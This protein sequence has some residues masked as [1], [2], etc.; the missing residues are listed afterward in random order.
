M[1][2]AM[3]NDTSIYGKHLSKTLFAS[4]YLTIDLREGCAPTSILGTKKGEVLVKGISM[5]LL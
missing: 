4:F 3:L 2:L 5:E 1:F